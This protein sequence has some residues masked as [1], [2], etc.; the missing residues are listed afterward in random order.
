[1]TTIWSQKS[2]AVPPSHIK[3]EHKALVLF[4]I[5]RQKIAKAGDIFECFVDL[6][7]WA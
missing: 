1:M 6:V 2:P 5:V 3:H 7:D 4:D